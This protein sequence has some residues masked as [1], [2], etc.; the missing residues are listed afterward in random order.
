MAPGGHG[1]PQNG[2]GVD[3]EVAP[4]GK[5]RTASS[6]LGSRR[7]AYIE[8][9]ARLSELSNISGTGLA[10]HGN[11]NVARIVTGKTPAAA[12]SN[13][14]QLA[15]RNAQFKDWSKWWNIF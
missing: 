2:W 7:G 6:R 1:S 11:S 14:V 15:G 8:F 13:L 9:D 5:Y 4:F 3:V 12:M 10:T